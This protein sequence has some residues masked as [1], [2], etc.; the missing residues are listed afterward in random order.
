MPGPAAPLP[1]QPAPVDDQPA[2]SPTPGAE[3]SDDGGDLRTPPP[4]GWPVIVRIEFEG[5]LLYGSAM[6][7]TRLLSKEGKRLDPVSLDEDVKELY[8]LEDVT[9]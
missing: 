8:Q 7:K 1:A 4:G 9:G 5:N 3:P 2:P 6:M